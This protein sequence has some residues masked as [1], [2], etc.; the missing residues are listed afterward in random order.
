MGIKIQADQLSNFHKYLSQKHR[1]ARPNVKTVAKKYQVPPFFQPGINF[2]AII[3]QLILS[4]N[5]NQ[6]EKALVS[7]RSNHPLL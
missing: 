4:P 7:I 5:Q 3:Q 6:K 1:P 2:A